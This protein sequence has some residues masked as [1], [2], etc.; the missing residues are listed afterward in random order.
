MLLHVLQHSACRVGV[1]TILSSPTVSAVGTALE[2]ECKRY[3]LLAADVLNDAS[4]LLGC[5][6]PA[7]PLSPPRPRPGRQQQ[8]SKPP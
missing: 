1:V 6:S 7:L 5:L 8:C 3:R 4:M 2:P